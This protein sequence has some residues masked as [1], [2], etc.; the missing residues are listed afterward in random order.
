MVYDANLEHIFSGIICDIKNRSF[1]AI[2]NKIILNTIN[3][4]FT[5]FI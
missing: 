1:T 5:I 4:N 2:Y 3:K